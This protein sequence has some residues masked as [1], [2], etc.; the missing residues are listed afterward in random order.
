MR[1]TTFSFSTAIG[2]PGFD[3]AQFL[4]ALRGR[5]FIIGGHNPALV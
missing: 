2:R 1:A 5:I 3:D 4:I